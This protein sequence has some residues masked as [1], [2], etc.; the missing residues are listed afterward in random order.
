M[1]PM[2]RLEINVRRLLTRCEFMAKDDQQTDWRLE[3][4]I[5]ALDDLVN[6][7]QTMPNKPSKDTITEYNRRVEF[8]KGVV[9][10]AKLSNP[11]ERVAAV[12]MLSKTPVSSIDTVR[13]NIATQIHQKTTAK[14]TKQLRDELFNNDKGLSDDGLRQRFSNTNA[15]DENLDAILKYNRNIQEKIAENMLSMIGNMKEHALTARTVIKNDI[16]SLDK[17]EK[18]TDINTD[19][20]KKES[21]KLE[22][23]T[24]SNWRCWVWVM[25]A[26]V[27]VVFFSKYTM[28]RA[29]DKIC[30]TSVSDTY[31]LLFPDM[32][33]FMKISKK[34]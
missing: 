11:V 18:L 6:E 12:Q 19:K 23:H 1:I 2:S 34:K 8:L 17:S 14:Y 31:L 5:L 10:T 22:E 25:V 27:L 16:A 9:G 20:L 3:K 13:P 29:S 30:S 15:H 7:L 24:K 26:F 21:V 33:L 4:F 32:V 28:V